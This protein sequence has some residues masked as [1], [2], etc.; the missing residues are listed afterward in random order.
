MNNKSLKKS[1]LKR[2]LRLE[3][4]LNFLQE[5]KD[6]KHYLQSAESLLDSEID[7]IFRELLKLSASGMEV[8][9][10]GGDEIKLIE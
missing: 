2:K 10:P 9:K 6:R 8:K 1:F 5:L 3:E 7:M 4:R